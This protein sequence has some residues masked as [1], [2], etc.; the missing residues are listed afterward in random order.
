MKL[1]WALDLGDVTGIQRHMP[2]RRYRLTHVALEGGRNQRVAAAPDEESG[3]LQ[4]AQP[5]PETL[6]LLEVDVARGG[7]YPAARIRS[8]KL[9]PPRLSC[10]K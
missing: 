3:R 6:G 4:V 7:T 2:C 10:A 8:T 9:M 1:A 5:V